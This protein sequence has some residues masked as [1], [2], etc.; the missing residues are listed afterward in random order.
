MMSRLS[1]ENKKKKLFFFSNYRPLLICNLEDF[2]FEVIASREK[3][4]VWG[5]VF[6]KHKSLVL[7]GNI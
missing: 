3:H 7:Y 6:Y 1:V 4:C 5:L 2:F